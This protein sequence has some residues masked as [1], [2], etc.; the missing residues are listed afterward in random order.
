M[1]MPHR[2]PVLLIIL[3]FSVSSLREDSRLDGTFV[4]TQSLYP[5]F[6]LTLWPEGTA[7]PVE[8]VDVGTCAHAVMQFSNLF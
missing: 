8:T 5:A 1:E 3:V 4:L 6:G 2:I 7:S